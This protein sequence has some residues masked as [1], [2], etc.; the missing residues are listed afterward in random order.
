MTVQT[1]DRQ[2]P[3]QAGL[4]FKILEALPELPKPANPDTA[5]SEIKSK[6]AELEDLEPGDRKI[7]KRKSA[8]SNPV[9]RNSAERKSEPKSEPK[10]ERKSEL[11]TA[12]A[13]AKAEARS[14]GKGKAKAEAKKTKS[15]R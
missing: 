4:E 12:K 14:E 9:Q 10:S 6:L 2:R 3:A 5:T 7:A 13:G 11:K 8:K 1:L 15:G